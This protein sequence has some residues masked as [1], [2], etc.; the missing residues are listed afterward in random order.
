MSQDADA[1]RSGSKSERAFADDA[2]RGNFESLI[3]RIQSPSLRAVA[4]HWHK[5]RGARRMPSWADIAATDLSPHLNMLWG[6]KYDPKTKEFRAELAGNRL[7]KWIDQN[8]RGERIQDLTSAS[9]YE[10]VHRHLIRIVTTPLA[11]R[12][13]GRLFT[14]GD[15]EVTGERI[16]LP[17]AE[18][19]K[20][21]DG[22]FG[23]SEYWP[24]P[25]LG[26]VE[27]VHE[28]LEWYEI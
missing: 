13:S 26:P 14:V 19:G 2:T 10:K 12:C 1:E 16:A 8:F 17:L 6:F 28:N 3:H 22:I 18:D 21:A 23:A 25:L 4:Q 15:Y 5:A 24:P 7:R 11:L 9:N 20:T 27:L